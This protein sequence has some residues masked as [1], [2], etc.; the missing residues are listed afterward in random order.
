MAVACPHI[1]KPR[2]VENSIELKLLLEQIRT[3]E[4]ER[5]ALLHNKPK[6]KRRPRR[7]CCWVSAG[8]GPEFASVLWSE[9]ALQTQFD[10]RRRSPL[11]P[12]L[13]RRLGKAGQS[14]ASRASRNR[15]TREHGQR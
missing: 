6:P 3:V 1:S 13:P 12:A 8:V 15:A 14:I 2:F 10:N 4:A 7:G 11:M 9:E 5:D